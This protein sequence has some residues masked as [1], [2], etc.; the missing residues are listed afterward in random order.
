MK[1]LSKGNPIVSN[2]FF[3]SFLHVCLSFC[4]K[5]CFIKYFF[6]KLGVEAYVQ[7]AQFKLMF[8]ASDDSI[9][10]LEKAL[11]HVRYRDEVFNS[12]YYHYIYH[13]FNFFFLFF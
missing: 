1:Q 5:S 4:F 10:L 3:S 8:G 9:K 7:F 2:T 6:K 12:S 11:I 13:Y